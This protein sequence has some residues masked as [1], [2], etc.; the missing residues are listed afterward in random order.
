MARQLHKLSAA[1]VAKLKKRGFYSDG[2]GLYLQVAP[3]GTKSWVFRFKANGKA[4]DMGLGPLHT[5]TL[6]EA[7]DKATQ[8]RKLRLEG[9][10]P[11]AKRQA[12]LMAARLEAARAITFEQ[13]A[14]AYIAR[15][16][17]GWKNAKHRQQWQNTLES[18][19]FPKLGKLAVQDIDDGLVVGVLEPLWETIP[20]TASRLRGRIET[21]LNWAGARKYRKGENPARWKGN[22]EHLLPKPSE[23]H[24]VKHFAALPFDE[25][26][27]FMRELRKQEG[28]AA[29]ALQFTILTAARTNETLNAK[30]SEFDLSKK[31]WTVPAARMKSRRKHRVPLSNAALA[32]LKHLEEARQGEYV[33][34]GRIAGK[35]L[36]DMSM[37][38]LLRRMK[39]KITAHGFRSTFKDWARERTSFANEISEAALAHVN[40]DKVEAAYARGDLFQK[41]AK[42]ME[43]WASYCDAG[44]VG[45]EVI[46]INQ[47]AAQ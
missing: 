16:S 18:Y 22:L 1:R 19:A 15:K 13:C 43:A 8:C 23:V 33:F 7:R 9:V 46:S 11:I 29:L 34:G 35:P 24:A 40:A 17:T 38:N 28:I 30:W 41:R 44:P 47:R 3:G 42:L 37:L 14:A 20:E 25:L 5:L 26:G 45:G 21:V 39:R 36:S 4:R 10:D 27:A 12:D 2:G 31:L 6:A 32:I